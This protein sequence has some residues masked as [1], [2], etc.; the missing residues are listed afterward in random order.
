MNIEVSKG[1][2]GAFTNSHRTGRPH[3]PAAAILAQAGTQSSIGKV[4]PRGNTQSPGRSYAASPRPVSVLKLDWVPAFAGMTSLGGMV[5]GR[6]NISGIEKASDA[7]A[8]FYR[9]R[10]QVRWGK[11]GTVTNFHL[12]LR[13]H[14]PTAVIPAKAGTQSSQQMEQ[15][16]R[17]RAQVPLGA[18]RKYLEGW[19][20][21]FGPARQRGQPG[22][23]WA[24]AF[25]GVT[26]V[27]AGA[28]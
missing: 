25:A 5:R 4:G 15:G 12:P 20:D 16:G 13:P 6:A 3:L 27:G 1:N 22:L 9:T 17:Y 21:A 11:S 19:I 14:L 7:V 2:S 23:G 28:L 24:P 26:E 10:G 18:D 8:N